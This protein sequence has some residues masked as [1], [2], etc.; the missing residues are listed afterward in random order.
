M[1]WIP[2]SWAHLHILVTVF[3]SV[4][5]VFALGLYIAGFVTNN[6]LLKRSC[7]VVFVI[8]G[9]LAIPTYLSGDHSMALLSEDPKVSKD[10]MSTHYG[11]GV[12]ALA[13]LLMTWQVYDNTRT[14]APRLIAHG[15]PGTET[16]PDDGAWAQ[17]MLAAASGR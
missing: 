1:H 17:V 16:V 9:L 11:W 14:E 13:V 6:E 4:G 10:L 12:V 8:L 15:G 3:P 5:L 7:L 2:Q